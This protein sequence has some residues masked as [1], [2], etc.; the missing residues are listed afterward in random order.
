MKRVLK[1]AGYGLAGLA[2]VAAVAVGGGMAASE[3]M[4]RWP[5][6]KPATRVVAATDPGAVARGQRLARAMGCNDCH[7]ANLEGRMFDDIPNLATLYAPNLTRAVARQS[8]ADLDRAIRHGVGSDG[9][10]L[11]IMPS[12]AF[13][14]LKDAE[15]A[16]LIAYL[17]SRPGSGPEQPHMKLGPIARV[18]IVLGQFHSEAAAIQAHENRQLPDL[19]PQYAAGRALARACVECHGFALEGSQSVLKTPDLGIAASYDRED[20]VRLLHTGVA[21]GD[22][23][24]GLMSD[25]APRRFKGWSDAEIGRLH[26]YLKARATRQVAAAATE[27]VAKR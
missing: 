9:R 21:A 23:K 4:Y 22:R 19:G 8:D 16:D 20:F 14:D 15:M 17:R 7:G 24:A 1:W 10:P 27:G 12:A 11:W 6:A 5:Q 13:A 26:D 25:I 3:A 2:G 18:G